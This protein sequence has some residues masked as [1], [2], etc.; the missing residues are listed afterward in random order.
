VCYCDDCQAFAHFLGRADEILDEHGGTDIFQ[1]S[2]GCLEFNQ[3]YDRLACVNLTG[4][5]TLRWYADCCKTPLGNTLAST[6]IP[7]LGLI[8]V[9]ADP[10]STELSLDEVTGH[11][12]AHV[13][14]K[15]AR[16]GGKQLDVPE[17]SL[18]SV[19]LRFLRLVIGWRWEGAHRKSPLFNTQTGQPVAEAQVLTGDERRGYYHSV[20]EAL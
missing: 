1:M 6:M 20:S 10:Q 4:K 17:A 7:F 2:Q 9:I 11:G 16:S 19:I 5:S 3:G 13:N 18:V 14:T 8:L 15:F 12:K